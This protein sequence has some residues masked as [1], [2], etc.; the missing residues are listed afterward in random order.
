[1]LTIK[2]YTAVSRLRTFDE[3]FEYLKLQ[4]M[5]GH[6]TFGSDRHLN[7]MLYTSDR[8]LATR[9]RVIVR[10]EGCDLGIEGREIYDQILVHHINPITVYDILN[11]SPSLYKLDNLICTTRNT[12]NAIHFGNEDTLIKLPKERRPGDTTPWL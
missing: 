11:D 4:G 12:H 8:W 3:R 7:Q 9:D 5:V 2:T 10:D 6:S 1:M